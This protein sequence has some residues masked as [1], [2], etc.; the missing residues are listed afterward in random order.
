M[1]LNSVD[2]KDTYGGTAQSGFGTFN[3]MS[4]SIAIQTG[5]I[6]NSGWRG[7]FIYSHANTD[8]ALQLGKVNQDQWLVKADKQVGDFKITLF[9]T[10]GQQQY[11]NVA[12]ITYPQLLAY[13]KRYGA[14]NNNP[15]SQQFHDYNNSQ[16]AT[17]M[18][19]VKIEGGSN[20][21]HFE[22]TAYTYS[23]WYPQYQNNGIDQTIEGNSS[24]AN[25]GTINSVKIPT[26]TGGSTK[27]PIIGVNPGDTVGYIKFN[28]YRAYGDIL[29]VGKDIDAGIASG[30]VRAGVWIEH[31][32]NSRFQ[33]YIDY[34]TY[35]TFPSLGNSTAASYKLDLTSRITNIQPFV[36]YDWRPIDGLTI[37]PGFKYESFTRNHNALVNQTTLQTANFS[38][39]YTAALPFLSVKYKFTPEITAYAQASKGFL[40]PTVSAFYVF[41]PSGNSI[42]PQ[43]TTNFQA[44]VVY[45][46]DKITAD[47]DAYQITATNFPLTTTYS[48]G[49]TVYQNA[50]TARYRGVEAEGSYSVMK[51]LSLYGSAA[52]MNSS[53]ISGNF[54]GLRV[55]DAPSYT[56]VAGAIYDDGMFFGSLLQ[57]FTGDYYGSS[58][59]RLTT[60]T[61]VGSM[62]HISGYNTLDFVIGIRSSVLHDFGIG[63]SVSA[64]L[65]IYNILNH[66]DTTGIGGDP[67]KA[68]TSINNTTMTYS[69]L[70]G[71]TIL[72]NLTIDF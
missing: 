31:V 45:K 51:G 4:N 56:L 66:Q 29:K 59:Q 11:N 7:L 52:L 37:T 42:Q 68:G 43:S 63:K 58:G 49:S 61:T 40:A 69:F 19:Y 53:Y 16:K 60:S 47:I 38:A 13:G 64:K 21:W 15:L 62:N 17:D 46:S 28:N 65:G 8:G 24:I 55:G 32:D 72:G 30:T 20:G 2:L 23:Y 10:Y 36:E 12:A 44:G 48:D 35:R 50:G 33:E 18:E 22:N 27:T 57:K 6:G 14:L 34:T 25:G 67:A 26:L 54:N 3:T 5:Q 71:R 9:G 70:P 41:N 1:A 39:T